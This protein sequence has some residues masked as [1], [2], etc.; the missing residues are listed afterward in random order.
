MGKFIFIGLL[1]FL[2]GV[3][4]YA[5]PLSCSQLEECDPASNERLSDKP[6]FV[7]GFDA[8]SPVISTPL[9]HGR[10]VYFTGFEGGV[11]ALDSDSGA[12]VWEKDLQ[13]ELGFQI[14]I[15]DGL[16]LV[17]TGF[18]RG[19]G[20]HLIAMDRITGEE[21]W[22]FKTDKVEGF[23]NPTIH[24]DMVIVST[25][26]RPGRLYAIDLET[27]E[28]IWRQSA[29]GGTK[30]PI[31][32]GGSLYHQD[33]YN[34]VYSLSLEDGEIQWKYNASLKGDISFSTP[35]ADTCCIYALVADYNSGGIAKIDRADGVEIGFFPVESFSISS[36]SMED[37]VLFFG[38]DGKNRVGPE[39]HM[40]A[41]DATNGKIIWRARVGGFVRGAAT[42]EG[43]LVYF[44][45]VD[46]H[47]YAVD[48]SSGE[49]QWRYEA[50]DMINSKPVVVGGRL[51]FG[52]VDGHVYVLE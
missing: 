16:V 21:K 8:G 28:E 44:G 34:S 27:G 31:I 39:G 29:T 32:Y 36:I 9:I 38:D 20:G 42:I 37:G 1:F 50:G 17:P 4:L 45:S 52:S 10:V 33:G 23:D 11:Y 12:V 48:R 43:D 51:L 25:T 22:R 35:V 30:K 26:S 49:I 24:N 14:A 19:K 40:N 3:G 41:M 5:S 6:E 15:N 47:M 46:N 13:R 7:W 2:T 18:N